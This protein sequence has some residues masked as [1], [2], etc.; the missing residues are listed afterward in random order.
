[1]RMRVMGAHLERTSGKY[2]LVLNMAAKSFA[3]ITAVPEEWEKLLERLQGG[4]GLMMELKAC[5]NKRS[6]SSNGLCWL[7]CERL[8]T[9]LGSNKEDVY[10]RHVRDVGVFM[11]LMIKKNVCDEFVRLWRAR[12]I[13][14]FCEVED[15][16]ASPGE[17]Y[18]MAYQG[19]SSYD[20]AQM[21]RLLEALQDSCREI[22]V[23][24]WPEEE[25][26]ALL[27]S[28]QKGRRNV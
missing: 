18:V 24:T 16:P 14:W 7:L 2:L 27:A 9:A 13:G 15:S 1:M 25:V 20:T 3:E 19:S 21:A 26:A 10:R 12:G 8:A 11:P 28:E 23:E 6:L 5:R 22:G 4:K 17:V